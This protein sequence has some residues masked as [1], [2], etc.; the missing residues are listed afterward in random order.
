[1]LIALDRRVPA[2]VL[3]T[4]GLGF[5]LSGAGCGD[6]AGTGGSG[7]GP[8]TSSTPTT[9]TTGPTTVACMASGTAGSPGTVCI[10]PLGEGGGGG[11]GGGAQGG[12][13][14]GGGGGGIPDICPSLEDARPLIEQ[15][16]DHVLIVSHFVNVDEQ[17]QCCYGILHQLCY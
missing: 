4:V 13:G 9:K 16:E 12:G 6:E 1:M 8:S 2:V 14:H 15:A 5:A 7:G 17:G 3:L 11:Q 10:A